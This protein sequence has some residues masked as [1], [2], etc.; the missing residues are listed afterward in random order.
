LKCSF[1]LGIP[2]T[3]NNPSELFVPPIY[4]NHLFTK[5]AKMALAVAGKKQG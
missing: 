1:L 5:N 2:G 4:N 3:L